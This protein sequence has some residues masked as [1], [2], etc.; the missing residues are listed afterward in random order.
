M[1]TTWYY[2]QAF[3][4]AQK[5]AGRKVPAPV[6]TLWLL[7]AAEWNH[8]WALCC[9]NHAPNDG[10]W[11]VDLPPRILSLIS[12]ETRQAIEGLYQKYGGEPISA[13][14]IHGDFEALVK[15]FGDGRGIR[16]PLP[17]DDDA[18]WQ[19]R[20][21]GGRYW[22]SLFTPS[23]GLWEV[24]LCTHSSSGMEAVAVATYDEQFSSWDFSYYDIEEGSEE[25]KAAQNWAKTLLQAWCEKD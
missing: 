1:K 8:A 7:I 10:Y 25:F 9:A 24:Q 14:D 20:T 17:T 21:L 22:L 11:Y 23:S 4:R 5:N 15:S 2:E 12:R 16:S 19:H 13:E 6:V 3:E 18:V